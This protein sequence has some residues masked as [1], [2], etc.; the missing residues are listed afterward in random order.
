M[1]TY[2]VVSSMDR[3]DLYAELRCDKYQFGEILV[4]DH[5]SFKIKIYSPKEN[6]RWEF[7]YDE[8]CK[9]ISI[10]KKQLEELEYPYAKKQLAIKKS[11][12]KK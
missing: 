3:E 1:L 2:G 8:F 7:D 12:I 4:D 10:A 5:L 11:K 9:L 6:G